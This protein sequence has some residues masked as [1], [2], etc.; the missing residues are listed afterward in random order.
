MPFMMRL[1]LMKESK[2]ISELT[3]DKVNKIIALL[4]EGLEDNQLILATALITHSAIAINRTLNQQPVLEVDSLVVEDVQGREVY[5]DAVLI[6]NE[7][8]S[9]IELEFNAAESVFMLAHLCSLLEK[10]NA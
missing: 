8:Q 5:T 7:L 9:A 6:L 4:R 1:D 2:Q 10:V 3:Y